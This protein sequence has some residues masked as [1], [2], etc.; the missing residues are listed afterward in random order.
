[1]NSHQRLLLFSVLVMAGVSLAVLGLCALHMAA[2][3]GAD[4]Q[5]LA[6]ALWL[7]AGSTAVIVAAGGALLF[8][9]G[10]RFSHRVEQSE[11][12]ARL[13]VARLE[14]LAED[15]RRQVTELAQANQDLQDFSHVASHDLK[16]PLR[17]IAAYCEILVEDYQQH[18]DA[19]GRR[20]L[21][22]LVQL[23]ARLSRLIDDLMTYSRMG[24]PL[25]RA[26]LEL[27]VVLSDVLA[28]LGPAI[29]RR[30]GRV[31]RLGRLPAVEADS[32]MTSVVLSNLISNG[33]KFNASE[34]PV[35]EVGG[36]PGT[37]P[38]IYV[39]D[40]GIGIASKHHEAIFGMFRRLHGRQEYEGSGAGLAIV[41][42]IVQSHGGR[43][44]VESQPG[45]GSTVF[46]TLAPAELAATADEAPSAPAQAGQEGG[47][48]VPHW[49]RSRG[50]ATE[51][52]SVSYLTDR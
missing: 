45:R 16:E 13:Q 20:M 47:S 26:H 41:R 39:R 29:D 40:N 36:L 32:T 6:D 27:D 46:F 17:G 15:L 7:A 22:T 38:V 31:R 14:A 33:L 35:V 49:H 24:R 3:P 10:F 19:E 42:R 18:L 23:C 1:M 37:P 52:E 44:W 51:T 43:V 8:R 25:E 50:S 4:P 21:G 30:R 12:R 28:T 11:A 48:A 34:Q 5:R 9:M 2:L